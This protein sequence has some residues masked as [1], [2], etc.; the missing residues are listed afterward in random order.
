MNQRLF[1]IEVCDVSCGHT[2]AV[3]SKYAMR[4]YVD[5][6]NEK[7]MFKTIHNHNNFNK[8]VRFDATRAF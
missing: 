3:T 8:I 7:K 2:E 1:L 4:S 5:K 6:P